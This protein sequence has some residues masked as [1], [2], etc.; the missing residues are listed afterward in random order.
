MKKKIF[1][2]LLFGS[3]VALHLFCSCSPNR[4]FL[5]N[6]EGI[7]T[8]NRHTGQLE[9]LWS[10]HEEPNVLNIDTLRCDTICPRK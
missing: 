8:Y 10:S 5:I 7:V 6:T 2:W 9:I 4:W 1:A 3:A